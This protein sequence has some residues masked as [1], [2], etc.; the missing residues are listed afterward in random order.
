M[1]SPSML[2]PQALRVPLTPPFAWTDRLRADRLTAPVSR[3]SALGRPWPR[4]G[5]I[6]WVL[7]TLVIAVIAIVQPHR[8]IAGIYR[9]AAVA[10]MNA[11][12]LYAP[13]LH[14][15]LY[16]PTGAVAYMPFLVLPEPLASHLWRVALSALLW[17]AI[18]RYARLIAPRNA[19]YAAGAIL[20]LSAPAAT[21]D[22]LRGQMTLPML[23]LLLFA[24]VD[25][26]S[27]RDRRGG[28]LLAAAVFVKPLA[29]V[30]ALLV[31]ATLP[32]ARRGLLLGGVCGVLLS[33]LHNDPIY[34][35]E[36]WVAMV[37]KLGVAAAPDSGTWFDVGAA[38]KTAGWLAPDATLFG[39]RAAAAIVCLAL[40]WLA[41][42]RLDPRTAVIVVMSLGCCYLLL[43]NPRV[44]EGS[45]VMLAVLA[46]GASV[47]EGE[48][49]ANGRRAALLAL[50]CLA[51]GTHMYGNTLYRP[52]AFWLKQVMAVGY[53]GC[54]VH[55]IMARRSLTCRATVGQRPHPAHAAR[56][57]VI[58][59]L[60]NSRIV[61]PLA[62]DNGYL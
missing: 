58:G 19:G 10:W 42:R 50:L 6:V 3:L 47:V 16:F 30:P 39:P 36:Q 43:F 62:R 15:Y 21:I 13:G 34:V 46:A 5:V 14:G 54:L 41:V 38:L 60:S 8:C 32:E 27:G 12:P 24:T 23:A 22:L 1:P 44:E 51:L 45:Y 26:A 49:P 31:F 9:A 59:R 53:V 28:L 56:S 55:V 40:A 33:F 17:V 11:E 61:P 2:S 18:R 37:G 25:L 35:V 20:L 29:L 7:T 4:L 48:R 57:F 52:T